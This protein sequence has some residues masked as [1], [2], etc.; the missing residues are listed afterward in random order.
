MFPLDARLASLSE[1]DQQ[2]LQAWVV[3]FERAWDVILCEFGGGSDV[4]HLVERQSSER[5]ETIEGNG[6]QGK[7]G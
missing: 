2:Q 3:E 7:T 5:R 4:D 6:H 1:A